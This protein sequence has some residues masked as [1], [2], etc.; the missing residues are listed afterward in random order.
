MEIGSGT[1]IAEVRAVRLRISVVLMDAEGGFAAVAAALVALPFYFVA[2]ALEAPVAQR[3]RWFR[4]RDTIAR[5]LSA[6]RK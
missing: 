2:T 5:G 1:R 6:I 3:S 4:M